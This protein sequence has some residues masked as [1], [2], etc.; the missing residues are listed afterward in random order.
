M[1]IPYVARESTI[2][3][4]GLF[5]TE[6]IARGTLL[7]RCDEQSVREH[8]EP[9]LRARIAGMTPKERTDFLEHVYTWEGKVVEILDDGK[10][11]NHSRVKQNTGNH[12][13]PGAGDGVSSY[14]LRDI[15]P[16]EELL[17]DYS[18][19]DRLEWFEKLC[20]EVGSRS[21]KVVGDELVDA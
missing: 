4:I 11:W 16:G 12:P 9:S 14:A 15:E 19:Y 1:Q 10:L 17:D 7:W 18:A 8:D 6:A 13:D 3:G 2:S 21:C 20:A 5:A